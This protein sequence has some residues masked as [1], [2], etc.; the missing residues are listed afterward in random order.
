MSTI[1]REEIPVLVNDYLI[2]YNFHDTDGNVLS[3][4]CNCVW[5]ETKIRQ[6]VKPFKNREFALLKIE[7]M[8]KR[9]YKQFVSTDMLCT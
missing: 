6:N 5:R 8:T 4:V 9:Y 3:K 7:F 2:K 1:D